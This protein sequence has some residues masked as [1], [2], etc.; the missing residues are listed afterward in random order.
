MQNRGLWR[1]VVQPAEVLVDVVAGH[2]GQIASIA[3]ADGDDWTLQSSQLLDTA[4]L[5]TDRELLAGLTQ[6]VA[7]ILSWDFGSQEY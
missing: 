5:R 7:K 2:G 3:A 6:A 4:R 1:F